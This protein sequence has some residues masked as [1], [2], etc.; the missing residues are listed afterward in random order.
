[1]AS[2]I[3]DQDIDVTHD[4]DV[5]DE[6][7]LLHGEAALLARLYRPRGAGSFPM[8]IELHGGAWCA[9]DRL[10]D[11]TINEPLARSGVVVASL[12][13]RMPP[14]AAYPASVS[15]INYAI[16]WLKA[17]AARLGGDPQRVGIAG[18]S[19]GGHL[20]ALVAMKPFDPAYASLVGE[21]APAIDATVSCVVMGWPVIE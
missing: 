15:D 11:V 14:V 21:V 8:M 6:A 20:A 1:M 3:H 7:Y 5:T 19:S 18:T 4:I 12:D 2:A 13:F 16:R 10:R 9:N 17:N